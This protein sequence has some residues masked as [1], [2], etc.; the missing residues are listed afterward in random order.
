MWLDPYILGLWLADKYWW[1]SSVGIS[2]TDERLI[3]RFSKWLLQ[4]YPPER[5]R[6]KIYVSH[7]E[8]FVS[9]EIM[10]IVPRE[11]IK[12]YL[13]K[14][15]SSIQYVLYVNSR[16]LKRLFDNVSGN[17]FKYLANDEDIIDYLAGRVD[18]DGSID[19]HKL[20][21]RIAYSNF[22]EVLTD[23]RLLEKIGITP[24]IKYYTTAR[25]YILEICC[26]EYREII[27]LLARKTIRFNTF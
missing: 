4:Y 5:L 9:T 14:K 11:N 15:L 23:A 16:P 18:G 21:L 13:H 25:E 3:L 27:Q 2:N 26:K 19:I 7:S 12:T 17:I 10:K 22:Y 1:G 8:K 20:R 6:L 24:K